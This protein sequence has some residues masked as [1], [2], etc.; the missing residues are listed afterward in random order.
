M[1][2]RC[3]HIPIYLRIPKTSIKHYIQHINK[4][5][6]L[7]L[8]AKIWR[9]TKFVI[10]DCQ[11]EIT[12]KQRVKN[13]LEVACA[14]MSWLVTY[15]Q[16]I[17]SGTD[18]DGLGR[19]LLPTPHLYGCQS[20]RFPLLLNDIFDLQRNCFSYGGFRVASISYRKMLIT[21]SLGCGIKR[22]LW[23]TPSLEFLLAVHACAPATKVT[24]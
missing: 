18:K 13:S 9:F 23:E 16:L 7:K 21:E 24:C 20:R 14:F 17:G 8:R 12:Y 2:I 4:N 19:G 15:K 3:L 5:I 22:L 6:A 11:M 1:T 10:G